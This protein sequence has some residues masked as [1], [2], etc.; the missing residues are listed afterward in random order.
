MNAHR[1]NEWKT[2]Y[3]TIALPPPQQVEK[4]HCTAISA[5]R[6]YPQSWS[7]RPAAGVCAWRR[8]QE[9]SG[10]PLFVAQAVPTRVSW[11]EERQP[12]GVCRVLSIPAQLSST[13]CL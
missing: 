6:N 9:S 4:G 2:R 7:I 3:D 1:T 12:A 8:A 11:R 5:D 10:M 13:E